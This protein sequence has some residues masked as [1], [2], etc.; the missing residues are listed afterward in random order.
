MFYELRSLSLAEILDA[1]FRLVQTEWRTLV[2]LSLIM[3]VPIA[4][5]AFQFEWLFDPF[6]Q[7]FE[8]GEEP[9]AERLLEMGLVG[10]GGM[11][12]YL[13]LYPFVAA[14]VTAAVG[15]LYLG[16][17]LEIGDAARAG[18]GAL[19]RL[20]MAVIAYVIAV[21][22]ACVVVIAIAA[23]A[24]ST[25]VELLGALGGAGTALGVIG[26]V[27]L[28]GV[29]VFWG[30][31]AGTVSAL[32]APVV[33]LESR[34]IFASV[35][36]AFSLGATARGRLIGVVVT[37]GLIVGFPVFGA[38]VMI[39]FVP[40]LGVLVWAGFQ[41]VGFAFTTATAVVLYF[42]LRCRSENYDLELLAEQVEAGPGLGQR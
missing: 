3:Q 22:F 5:L 27:A 40:V 32:L 35:G 9:S 41:A 13:I 17:H 7:P 12:I 39:G 23:F 8:P 24:G 15:N 33:V 29:L 10:G 38:Q 31:Y 14:A 2:G 34:G 1:A 28:A 25:L 6:A 16:R 4:L 20:L 18:L 21:G 26:G 37:A 36:R 42:D 30:L 19:V 11:L